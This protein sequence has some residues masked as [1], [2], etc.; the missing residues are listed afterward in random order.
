MFDGESRELGRAFA[1]IAKE[2]RKCQR[3]LKQP[4]MLIGGGESIVTLNRNFGKGGPNQEFVVSTILNLEG[5]KNFCVAGLDTDGT[6]GPTDVAGAIADAF[7]ADAADARGVK[8][9]NSL[10][11]H[12]VLPALISLDEIIVT[13]PT[14]TNVNDLKFLILR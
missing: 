11:N 10:E 5:Q 9:H 13:G 3:P 1:S 7:T 6:D 2:I 4:C 14:G 12:E 8:L